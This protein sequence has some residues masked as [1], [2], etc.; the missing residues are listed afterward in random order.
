MKHRI[1][2]IFAHPDDESFGFAGTLSAMSDAGHEATYVVGTRGEVG[3]ILVEGLA[4]RENLGEVREGELRL[5]L[6]LM[7]VSDLRL[8]GYRDSGMAGSDENND[9]RAFINQDVDLVS[10][11]IA[12]IILEKKPTIVLTY[13]IDGIYGHPD[14]IMAHKVATAAV[15][16]AGA[17]GWQTPNLYYSSASRER[18]KRMALLPNSPFASMTPKQLDS[19]GTPAAEITTWLD[20]R[21]YSARKLAAIKAHRTQVGDNGPFAQL[22]EEER[23]MWLSVETVRI[24]PLPWNPEPVDVLHDILPSAAV[25]HPLRK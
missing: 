4:T 8:L 9:P 2:V 18:I 21:E 23:A 14:H 12:E 1:V 3:E 19:F 11:A 16:K 10:D 5:A 13:G 7:G 25:D 6:D 24:I 20:I 15:L 17:R 22:S